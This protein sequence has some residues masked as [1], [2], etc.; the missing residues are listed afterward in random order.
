PGAYDIYLQDW[1]SWLA[2][3]SLDLVYPQVYRTTVS[4]YTTTLDQ[5]LSYLTAAQ[6]AKVAPGIRAISGTPPSEVLGMVAADRARSLAGHVFWYE[7]QIYDDLPGLTANYFQV[8]ATVPQRPVDFRPPPVDREENDPGTTV[9]GF[10]ILAVPNSHGGLAAIAPPTAAATDQVRFA[11]PVPNAGLYRVQVHVPSGGGYAAAIPHR[12][13][14]A[15]GTS[16]APVDAA[17]TGAGGWHELGTYWFAGGTAHVE[18]GAVPGVVTVAD[19]VSLLPSRFRSGAM[20]TVGAGTVGSAGTAELALAGRAC[21]GGELQLQAGSLAAAAPLA[22]VLGFLPAATPMFGGTLT[23]APV[24]STFALAGP[25]GRAA[26]MVP[27]PFVPALHGLAVRAQALGLDATA[28]GGVVLTN[29]V[30]TSLP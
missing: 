20:T 21:L 10:L 22:F 11:L 25:T 12:V 4:A 29:G 9:T 1:P 2:N 30:A 6:R 23:L 13:E 16:L 7:A 26:W 18:V 19:A 24:G 15:A 28:T 14:H 3:G 5:Q 27:L 17:A 8:P